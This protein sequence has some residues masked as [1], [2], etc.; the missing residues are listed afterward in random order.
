M[1][2][3]S[4]KKK[5]TAGNKGTPIPS[6]NIRANNIDRESAIAESTR[7]IKNLFG[8]KAMISEIQEDYTRT[9]E[10][11]YAVKLARL[12]ISQISG[13]KVKLSKNG[14]FQKSFFEKCLSLVKSEDLSDSDDEEIMMIY[15]KQCLCMLM[16]C[17]LVNGSGRYAFIDQMMPESTLYP[18]LF[19]SFWND[20]N[21][22]V[23]FPSDPDAANDLKESRNILAD[24]ILHRTGPSSINEIANEF[25]EL[26]GFSSRNNLFMISFLDFY[27]FTW[28]KH[29]G[30][31]KYSSATPKSPVSIQLTACGRKMLSC[32][33]R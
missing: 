33:S 3:G 5:T 9:L 16:A 6:Y 1:N 4:F 13:K 15:I 23:I 19:R 10:R 18:V 8:M 30:L 17:G 26:T 12:I 24:I 28:L 7:A 22:A 25:F 11:C 29:F 14:L 32:R 2:K 27:F 31:L 21:W 20:S